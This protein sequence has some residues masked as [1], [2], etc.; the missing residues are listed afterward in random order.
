MV[1]PVIY[2]LCST[3]Y[4]FGGFEPISHKILSAWEDYEEVA[5]EYVNKGFTFLEPGHPYREL[6][7]M[8]KLSAD[9]L[10]LTVLSM[11]EVPVLDGK[12]G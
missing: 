4:L 6:G 3:E 9:G 8:K 10:I 5:V 2:V 1:S 12:V 7:A 11:E